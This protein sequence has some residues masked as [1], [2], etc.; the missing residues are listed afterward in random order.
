MREEG[1][2]GDSGWTVCAKAEA[3]CLQA[4]GIGLR[5]EPDG[6][7]EAQGCGVQLCYM[8]PHT[9]LQ[10]SEPLWTLEPWATCGERGSHPGFCLCTAA[11][12]TTGIF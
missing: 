12:A 11:D 6:C 8:A 10:K 2:D 5:E 7:P 1:G 9:V 3:G 4:L